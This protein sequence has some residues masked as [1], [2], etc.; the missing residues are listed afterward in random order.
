[1]SKLHAPDE[2]YQT[3]ISR[4]NMKKSKNDENLLRKQMTDLMEDQEPVMKRPQFNSVVA[5]TKLSY[6]EY[7]IRAKENL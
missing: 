5:L 2:G 3:V 6:E 7:I 4:T 1:M